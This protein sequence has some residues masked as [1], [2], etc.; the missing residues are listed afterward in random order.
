MTPGERVIALD[1][2]LANIDTSKIIPKNVEGVKADPP[3]IFFSKTSAV[4]VNIDGD[5]IWAPIPQNDLKTAVN[6]N[7]DLFEHAPTKTY[8]LRN[9]RVWLKAADVKGPW[10][11]AGTLPES[12]KKLPADD[13]WKEVKASPPRPVDQRQ[14]GAE[15]VRQHAAGGVDSAARRAELSGRPGGETVSSGS[16]TPRATCSGWASKAPVYFLVAGRWF[17]APDFTGPWTFATPNLPADVQAD[18]ARASALA[19]PR[20]GAWHAAGRRSHSPRADSADGARQQDGAGARGHVSGRHRR[21]QA[22]RDDHGAACGEYR[23]GHPQGR[24]PLLHVLRRRVVH[25]DGGDGPVEGH[26]RGAEADLRDSR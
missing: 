10:G 6:T 1:R 4:L 13:N 2:V 14:P 20:V 21:V 23:Q 19:R 26:G 16:A 24:R 5:P 25:V 17:S 18:S 8:Y 11:P 12:F 7:W 9:D 3:P 22:D 15:G